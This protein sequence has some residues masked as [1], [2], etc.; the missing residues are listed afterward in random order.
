M[1]ILREY[2]FQSLQ[3]NYVNITNQ[4][5]NQVISKISLQ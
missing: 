4:R 2:Q 3:V 1:Y 5:K